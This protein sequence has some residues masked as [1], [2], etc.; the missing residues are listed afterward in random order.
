MT[1]AFL[2]ARSAFGLLAAFFGWRGFFAGLAF[3]AD[4][5]LSFACGALVSAVFSVSIV[6]VLIMLLLDRVAVVTIH[7]S[8][9]ERH[10]GKSSVIEFGGPIGAFESFFMHPT[11]CFGTWF[12]ASFRMGI[13]LELRTP[14]YFKFAIAGG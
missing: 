5:R 1:S 2:L 11:K 3:L 13:V 6:L 4:G 14:E 8:G 10:Q 9:R 7:H 12:M